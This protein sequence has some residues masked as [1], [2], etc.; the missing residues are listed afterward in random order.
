[1]IVGCGYVGQSLGRS[2]LA[3][4]HAVAG[5][6]T[7][8]HREPDLLEAGITP[9]VQNARETEQ[10]ADLLLSRE[11]D[12]VFATLAAGRDGDYHRV[13]ADGLRSVAEACEIGGVRRL[14]YT[15]S[16]SIYTQDDG[17]RVDESTPTPPTTPNT[18]ALLIAEQAVLDQSRG[19]GGT[20]L[21]LGGIY[22]PGRDLAQRIRQAAGTRRSD[23]RHIVNLIHR[24][25]I[26]AALTLLLDHPYPG[27][28]NLVDD[29]P[30]PRRDLYDAVLELLGLEP[31]TWEDPPEDGGGGLGK[32]VS[33]DLIKEAL[34]LSLLHPAFIPAG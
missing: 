8:R 2:L 34:G 25:D 23:G 30:L 3:A 29:H 11:V 21:R 6:T 14:I 17:S 27:V 10:L 19:F 16:T 22:G 18:A 31:I 12:T 32:R 20:V 9:I 15:S 28:L 1:L 24:D 13:Y 4:G 7:T 33:N 5:T 26:V